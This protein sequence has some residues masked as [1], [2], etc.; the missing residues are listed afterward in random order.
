[1]PESKP[2]DLTKVSVDT[3]VEITAGMFR[4]AVATLGA[5]C[6]AGNTLVTLE[7]IDNL[8]KRVYV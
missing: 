7:R 2:L 5:E 3:A 1:M 8:L 6:L 4:A